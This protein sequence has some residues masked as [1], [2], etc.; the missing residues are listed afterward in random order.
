MS[1]SDQDGA[2]AGDSHDR[3]ILGIVHQDN[4]GPGYF[5]QVIEAHGYQLE[6]TSFASGD[7]S[8]C[9]LRDF[10]AVM[11][12]GGEAQVDEED[13][14]SWL[15]QEKRELLAALQGSVPVLGVCLGGQLL[16]DVAGGWVG[17]VRVERRAWNE[18]TVLP[19]AATDPVFQELPPSFTTVVWHKYEFGLPPGATPLARTTSALQAFR[20]ADRPA[21][22]LQFHAEANTATMAGWLRDAHA[23]GELDDEE[24]ARHLRET[25]RRAPHQE[26]LAAKIC[27]GFLKEIENSAASRRDGL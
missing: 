3:T 9:S 21:W 17:P 12:F 2:L 24:L 8:R 6:L 5:A 19:G 16:A 27:H 26:A 4:A 10:A 25:E 23:T 13:R 7:A 15:V 20:L 1:G 22:G 11:V 14:H 18:V